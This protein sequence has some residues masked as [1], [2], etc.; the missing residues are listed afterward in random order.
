MDL[1]R[2]ESLEDAILDFT[3]AIEIDPEYKSAYFNRG[4]G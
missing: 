4:I 2:L 3:K 1:I